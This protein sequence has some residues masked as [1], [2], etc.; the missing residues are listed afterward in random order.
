LY[1][2]E[3]DYPVYDSDDLSQ[4]E[5]SEQIE[6]IENIVDSYLSDDTPSEYAKNIFS[7]LWDNDQES[8]INEDH[9]YCDDLGVFC[10][11][12]ALGYID[13]SDPDDLVIPSYIM[14]DIDRY[15]VSAFNRSNQF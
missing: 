5:Y 10:A 1:A 8:I 4:R 9:S 12:I 13:I 6:S 11:A 7:W 3:T 15:I 2:L 14:R